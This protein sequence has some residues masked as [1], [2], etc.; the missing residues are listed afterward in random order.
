[1]SEPRYYSVEA[2][3]RGNRSGKSRVTVRTGGAYAVYVC[4]GT[5]RVSMTSGQG[6][7]LWAAL[8][9]ALRDS[10]GEPPEWLAEQEAG[11]E[12]AKQEDDRRAP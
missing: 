10:F 3:H 6:W 8:G 1:M 12:A 9:T 5:D 7:A 11:Q 2:P 4:V